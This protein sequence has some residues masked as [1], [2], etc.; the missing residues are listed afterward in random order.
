MGLNTLNLKSKIDRR[1]FPCHHF[2]PLISML[3]T[4]SRYS[5]KVNQLLVPSSSNLRNLNEFLLLKTKN[6]KYFQFSLTR[7]LKFGHRCVWAESGMQRKS[8]N[9]E[10]KGNDCNRCR[11][12]ADLETARVE[13][14]F[15]G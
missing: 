2:L 6:G 8:M 4:L 9:K 12:D 5:F 15:N 1:N 3:Y 7:Q 13:K 10:S 14:P 11:Q